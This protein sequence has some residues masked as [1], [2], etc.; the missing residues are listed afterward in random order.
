M[1]HLTAITV[2]A[3]VLCGT[4]LTL[5]ATQ[6]AG[7]PVDDLVARHLA[8]R[9]GLQR[10]R[11]V[12]TMKIARTVP[13]LGATLNLV[14]YKKRQGLYRS[15]QTAPGRPT[16]LRGLDADG[17]WEFVN[18]KVTRRPDSMAVELRELDGDIDGMLVDYQAKG[19]TV[20]YEGRGTEAGVDV[21]KLRVTLGSGA[22][23]HVLLDARTMLERKHIGHVTL[24]PDRKVATTILFHDY[25]E[26]GGLKFPFAI[27]EDRDAMGQTYAFYVERID[28]DVPVDDAIFHPPAAPG[29]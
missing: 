8:A 5:S 29:E 25:R 28:L 13:T 11:A 1:R 17:L 18:D 15:E 9:G 2:T 24:A 26:V 14:I 10:I 20:V 4:A 23:R 16:V 22:I 12:Q 21:H 19:H 3:T 7:E 27:D 6:G